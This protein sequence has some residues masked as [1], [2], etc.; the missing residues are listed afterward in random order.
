MAVVVYFLT[1][2]LV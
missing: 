2:Q 1:Y